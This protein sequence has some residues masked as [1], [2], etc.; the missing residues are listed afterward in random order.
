MILLAQLHPAVGN[1]ADVQHGPAPQQQWRNPQ[2]SQGNESTQ[3]SPETSQRY[4][5][6]QAKRKGSLLFEAAPRT[7]LADLAITDRCDSCS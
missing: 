7:L 3:R 4:K 6:P 5:P 2:P 1:T